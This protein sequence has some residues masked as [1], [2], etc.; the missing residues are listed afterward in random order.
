ML[1]DIIKIEINAG[2]VSWYGAIVATTALIFTWLNYLRDKAKLKIKYQKNVGIAGKNP[3]YDTKKTYFNVS[4]I[5]TGR[6]PIR[7]SKIWIQTDLP[8]NSCFILGDSMQP[9]TKKVLT[10]EDPRGEYFADQST[11]KF[12]NSLYVGVADA[13]GKIYKKKMLFFPYF[14]ILKQKICLPFRK[15]RLRGKR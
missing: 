6:R 10:E 4:V 5:N 9:H 14:R 13:T 1:N 7:I 8:E 3:Y 15:L 2:A 12:K 11:I